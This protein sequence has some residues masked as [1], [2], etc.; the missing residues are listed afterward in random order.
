[1]RVADGAPY[2]RMLQRHVDGAWSDQYSFDDAHV[3]PQDLIA[4]DHFM[5]THP[6]SHF[7]EHRFAA[8]FTPAGRVGLF[9][10]RLTER[11]YDAAAGA[12]VRT[13]EDVAL[14]EGWLTR[15]REG[16]GI[17]L[18]GLT[19]AERARLLGDA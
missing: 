14:D 18:P 8:R 7:R 1:M 13:E 17:E 10:G 9:D 16:F 11:R 4:A 5:Q 2:G 12:H 15:L 19:P 3:A 6:L